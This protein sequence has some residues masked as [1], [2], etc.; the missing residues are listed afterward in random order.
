MSDS[1]MHKHHAS[2]DSQREDQQKQLTG[3]FQKMMM[4]K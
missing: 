3:Y 2:L 4:K 1:F